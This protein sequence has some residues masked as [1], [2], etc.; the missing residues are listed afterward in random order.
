MSTLE[1]AIAIASQAHE[2]QVDKA[3]APYILHP[4]RMMLSVDTPE[5]RMAA[6]LHDV[7]EDTPITLDQLRGEGFPETVIE[8]VEALT[9]RPEEE[10]DYDAFIRRVAPNPLA[11]TVKLAD[12]RDNCDMSRIAQPT[13]K[14]RR[15]IEKYKRAIQY[16][17]SF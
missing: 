8:A 9:K 12:L 3:G 2:G 14:D 15:R 5:A 10:N 11:R 4:L 17:E 16:L 6:V 1:R 13:E 7:V